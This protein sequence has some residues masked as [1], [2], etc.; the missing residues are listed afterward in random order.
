MNFKESIRIEFDYSRFRR[1]LKDVLMIC[2]VNCKLHKNGE[3]FEK[4]NNY[5]HLTKYCTLDVFSVTIS[6]VLFGVRSSACCLVWCY[7]R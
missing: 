5:W 7:D 1:A 6:G 2:V 3:Y 4:L